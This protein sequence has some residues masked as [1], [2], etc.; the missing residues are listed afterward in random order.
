MAKRFRMILS[1]SELL[2]SIVLIAVT[3]VAF[4]E[5]PRHDF[6]N[7]DDNLYVTD[8]RQVQDGLTGKGVL[9]AFTATHASNWHP[10]TWL[11]HMLDCQIF[12]L[13]PF[14]H[15]L[16]SIVL[17]VGNVLL[18]FLVFRQMTGALW[19][20]LF[21]SALFAVHPLHVESVAWVSERK[22]VLSTFFWILTMWAYIRYVECPKLSRYLLA[23]LTFSMGLLSKPMLVTLPFVLLLLDYWPLKRLTKASSKDAARR[24]IPQPRNLNQM[25]YSLRLVREKIPFF[26]L[27]GA[28]CVVTFFAQQHGGSVSSPDLIPIGTRIAN[29]LISYVVY[30]EK[31]M[32]PINLA[33]IYPFAWDLPL[34]QVAAA[35]LFLI[36]MSILVIRQRKRLPY[37]PV[38]WFWYL[39]TLVPVIGLVQVGPQAMADRYTYIPH[40]GLFLM[41]AW[42]CADLS[43]RWRYQKVLLGMSTSLI[44]V[45]LT[46][47]TRVQASHWKNSITL[48]EHTSSIT[49]SN[50]L[51]HYNLGTALGEAGQMEK[52]IFHLSKAVRIRP[53][54]GQAHY[55]LGLCLSKQGRLELAVSHY[56][57]ALKI[58]PD[59]EKAHNNLG[60]LL[61]QQGR[62]DEAID[63]FSEALRIRPDFAEAQNNLRR[64]TQRTRKP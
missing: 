1:R 12:G 37:L 42:W 16:T 44:L 58:M 48:F 29:G 26:V 10:L 8:N 46:I 60:T 56:R 39:G 38:G 11:S 24:Q 17:H 49:A 62:L 9:W 22:D 63:H 7:Y 61:A 55:N 34:W 28:S 54:Y 21:V 3:L 57:K 53:H 43:K 50:A 31:T 51:A 5:V 47:T 35:G 20:C 6:V 32:W 36:C 14:G 41:L 25:S 2:V 33:A 4:W 45:G 18:L 19:Q 15:H 30:I 52:A 23:L 27:S 13:K 64:A 59:D 40:I